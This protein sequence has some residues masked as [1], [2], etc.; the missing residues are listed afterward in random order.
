[1]DP[2]TVCVWPVWRIENDD[3]GYPFS[4]Y[5]ALRSARLIAEECVIKT[6]F[7]PSRVAASLTA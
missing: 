1:M 7:R 3:I 6:V 2:Q 4:M 5:S